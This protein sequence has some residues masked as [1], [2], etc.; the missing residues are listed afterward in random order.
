MDA[1][2]NIEW[3]LSIEGRLYNSARR[4]VNHIK[5]LLEGF[6]AL[7]NIIHNNLGKL[8]IYLYKRDD[9]KHPQIAMYWHNQ[10]VKIFKLAD[11]LIYN[12]TAD[13]EVFYGINRED[14]REL[15][16]KKAIEY[17]VYTFRDKITNVK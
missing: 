10:I 14:V 17:E 9:T 8:R 6:K 1:L 11:S 2:Q 13:D 12:L 4:N 7:T 5:D 3:N 15:L 16:T